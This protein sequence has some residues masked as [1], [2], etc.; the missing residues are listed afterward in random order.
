MQRQLTAGTQLAADISVGQ[1]LPE[2]CIAFYDRN[3]LELVRLQCL[4]AHTGR[5][6]V[7]VITIVMTYRHISISTGDPVPTICF[8]HGFANG[9]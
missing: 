5:C 3:F 4:F 8:D 6:D 9:F 2:R 7:K 1:F